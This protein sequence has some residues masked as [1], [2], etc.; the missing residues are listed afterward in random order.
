MF[1]K[2]FFLS[3]FFIIQLYFNPAFAHVLHYKGL[4]KLEFDLYRNNELIGQHIFWF[5]R[6]TPDTKVTGTIYF[7]IH[8]P[9]FP[10]FRRNR[11]WV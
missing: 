7:H 1:K 9:T 4:H 10:S 6:D 2:L 3:I 5:K 8:M 11:L